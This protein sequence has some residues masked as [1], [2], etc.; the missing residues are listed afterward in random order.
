MIFQR[1]LYE[2]LQKLQNERSITSP[3]YILKGK[4]SGQSI[5]D[6][7][8]FHLHSYFSIL[9][10]LSKQVYDEQIHRFLE[11]GIIIEK[12]DGS[13]YVAMSEFENIPSLYFDGWHYRGNEHIFFARLSL[14]VQTLSHKRNEA[15]NFIPIQK[16]GQIQHW[17]RHFLLSHDYQKGYLHE[18]LYKEII[19]SFHQLQCD[20][21]GKNIVINRLSGFNIPGITWSQ[22]ANLVK[23]TELDVQ[24]LYVSCLHEWLN[25]IYKNGQNYPLLSNI[26]EG[27]RFVKPLTGSAAQTANLFLQGYTIEQISSIRNIKTSTVEDHL[28]ELAMNDRTFNI[29]QFISE[30]DVRLVLE[31]SKKKNTKKLKVIR[32]EV[33]HLSFFQLRLALARGE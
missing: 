32:E 12:S 22:L 10:K 19:E 28:I 17:V 8:I 29:H 4:R 24:L 7:G 20:E 3:F 16:N 26:S 9:P 2:L 33:P 30:K 21:A 6:V 31:I 25:E 14:I 1:I 15:M 5:Q 11:K 18:V 27:I 13:F 23:M